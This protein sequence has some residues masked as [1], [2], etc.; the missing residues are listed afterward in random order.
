MELNRIENLIEKY[1][2][3]QTTVAEEKE[4]H[5]YF[6]STNVAQHLEQ[7]KELF[8]YFSIAKEEQLADNVPLKPKR[9]IN[10][11]RL[12]VAASVLLFAGVISHSIYQDWRKQRI[13]NETKGALELV[14]QSF[15]KGT[16][17]MVYIN[18]FENT[19]NQIFKN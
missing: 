17:N 8:G 10:F 18:E 11:R 13:Y 5:A 15:N 3:A 16:S 7:Y 2:E 9:K 12:S 1:F 14:S 19:K 4:L 6:S